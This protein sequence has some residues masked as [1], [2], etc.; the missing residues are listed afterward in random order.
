MN[1]VNACALITFK[2][3]EE[4]LRQGEAGDN[5]YV[6]E[7]GECDVKYT[8]SNKS[9]PFLIYSKGPGSSF[10]ERQEGVDH[11]ALFARWNNEYRA[12]G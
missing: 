5:W 7:K 8:V 12:L 6:V 10:G 4:I 3:G 11:A 9:R 1:L 2:A